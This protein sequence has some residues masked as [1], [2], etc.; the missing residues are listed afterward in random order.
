[1]ACT[2]AV[3]RV[4]PYR[5]FC[6]LQASCQNSGFDSITLELGVVHD[7]FIHIF[8]YVK[9]LYYSYLQYSQ[10][11]EQSASLEYVRPKRVLL[12][13][14]RHSSRAATASLTS[15]FSI[16]A[17]CSQSLTVYVPFMRANG[18]RVTI[19]LLSWGCQVII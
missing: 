11:G 17:W 7:S 1:M 4:A 10:D 13:F 6:V 18:R 3:L 9:I 12:L 15:S 16:V 5:A 14:L 19:S 8:C 2:C